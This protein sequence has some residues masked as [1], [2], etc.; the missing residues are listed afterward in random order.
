MYDGIESCV[1][2][3]TST[4]IYCESERKYLSVTYVSSIVYS[5]NC[6]CCLIW[7][8]VYNGYF[9]VGSTLPTPKQI[10]R[11]CVCGGFLKFIAVIYTCHLPYKIPLTIWSYYVNF[12]L[13]L[14]Y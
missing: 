3:Y 10:A 1:F 2:K 6:L 9:Y 5:Y 11:V 13:N 7:V 8:T 4:H 12:R 14:F